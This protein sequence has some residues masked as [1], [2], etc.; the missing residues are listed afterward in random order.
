VTQPSNIAHDSIETALQR[1]RDRMTDGRS[2]L[3]VFTG[4]QRLRGHLSDGVQCAVQSGNGNRAR[5]LRGVLGE[6]DRALEN[7]FQK[8]L[9][10][11]RRSAQASR[12]IEAV[13]VGRDAAI[14]GRTE[15]TIPAF[16]ALTNEGR[17]AF[18]TGYLDPLIAGAQKA[19]P[20]VNKGRPLLNDAVQAESA[21]LA[22][23]TI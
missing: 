21:A 6:V 11:N 4:V 1:F 14:R 3:S 19:A 17:A 20:G 16:R 8:Y 7:A 13:S 2:M 9:A 5:L 18:R 15:D 12:N 10:A 22:P 23:G